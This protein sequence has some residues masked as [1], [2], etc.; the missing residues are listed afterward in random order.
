[1]QKLKK[2]TTLDKSAM[3]WREHLNTNQDPNVKDQLEANR[4]GGGYLDK[5][6]FLQRVE[7]RKDTFLDAKKAG[8]RRR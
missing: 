5:V 7:E 6:E 3:D 2:M 8:K 4:K 1:M